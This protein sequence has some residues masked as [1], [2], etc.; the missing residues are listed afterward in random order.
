MIVQDCVVTAG[1]KNL[2]FKLH[3][4]VKNLFF[5]SCYD[6][7]TRKL[8]PL[9]LL[10]GIKFEFTFFA[11]RGSFCNIVVFKGICI[12]EN[13]CMRSANTLCFGFRKFRKLCFGFR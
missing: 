2:I 8:I 9:L 7:E 10:A 11:K 5:E 12:I 3:F 4:T 13:K 6:T 1:L